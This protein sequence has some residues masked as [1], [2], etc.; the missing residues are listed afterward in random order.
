MKLLGF[1]RLDRLYPADFLLT[2]SPV[3]C[4][5]VISEVLPTRARFATLRTFISIAGRS[6]LVYLQY[7]W[8]MSFVS[9][10]LWT[11]STAVDCQRMRYI[12][13]KAS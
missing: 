8:T 3:D 2:S 13:I 7:L 5:Q 4:I 11:Q 12:G 10:L 1:V 6:S 9:L